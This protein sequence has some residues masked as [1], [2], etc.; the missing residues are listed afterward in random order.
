[1]TDLELAWLAGLLEGEA[2]FCHERYEEK[3]TRAVISIKMTDR[4]VIERVADLVGG[5]RITLMRAERAGYKDQYRVR[6]RGA[7]AREIM[8]LILPYMGE[9]RA[10]KI[11]ECLTY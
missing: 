7:R 9:R 6:L 3:Y 10:A 4:D 11:R 1:M 2:A 8:Q 5:Q